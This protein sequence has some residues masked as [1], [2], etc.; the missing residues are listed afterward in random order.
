M[1]PKPLSGSKSGI[2]VVHGVVG[3]LGGALFG[4]MLGYLGANWTGNGAKASKAAKATAGVSAVGWG[5][6]TYKDPGY[7]LPTAAIPI[8]LCIPLGVL[9]AITASLKK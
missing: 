6:V 5:V 4:A 3:A 1:Q 9:T 2:L 8:F 7:I